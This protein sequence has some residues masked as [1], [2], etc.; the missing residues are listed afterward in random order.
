MGFSVGSRKS[1]GL[2]GV[3]TLEHLNQAIC[4]TGFSPGD[5]DQF[6][7]RRTLR[8]TPAQAAAMAMVQ[9]RCDTNVP[10]FRYAMAYRA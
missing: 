4:G 10:Y 8:Q 6:F 7:V 1:T 5:V 3:V 9:R 2:D